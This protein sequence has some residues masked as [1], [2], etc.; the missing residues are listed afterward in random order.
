MDSTT[1]GSKADIG[2]SPDQLHVL[3]GRIVAGVESA[4]HL[5]Q[6]IDRKLAPSEGQCTADPQNWLTVKQAA[7]SSGSSYT[8]ILRAIKAGRLKASCLNPDAL[9]PTYRIKPQD[10]EAWLETNGG[11][12]GAPPQM[13]KVRRKVRSRYFGEM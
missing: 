5:L 10:L 1:P 9:R 4:L 11:A 3:L 8:S 7:I 13:P 2:P 12:T 6:A